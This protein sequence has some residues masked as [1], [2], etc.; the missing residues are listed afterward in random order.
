M[1]KVARN[2]VEF[3][4][5]VRV[6]SGKKTLT[7]FPIYRGQRD[8]SWPLLPKI[9]RPP[10][11]GRPNMFCEVI[12]P[13]LYRGQDSD[14]MLVFKDFDRLTAS[15]MP[16]WVL[17]GEDET[18]SWRKLLLAQ[19]HGLATRLLDW[20]MNP[21]VA[22]Y[23]AVEDEETECNEKSPCSYCGSDRFHDSAVYVLKERLSFSIEGL[24]EEYRSN[25]PAPYYGWGG[26]TGNDVGVLCP[27]NISPRVAAQ[28]S[29]FTIR[30]IPSQE[31]STD[32]AIRIPHGSREAI[33][34]EL[35]GLGINQGTLFPDL[36]G[37]AQY[38]KW[39]HPGKLD[40]S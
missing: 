25:G 33:L 11:A 31:I 36:D 28:G 12:A 16:A 4:E 34:E 5:A 29:V 14:E 21:L 9:A 39:R 15:M 24:V 10:F 38:L 35:D 19:H 8:V 13:L 40:G 22:L 27:P 23:F 20:T 6:S 3:L 32:G 26:E 2:M 17:Q 1:E 30:K 37:V 7:C 18:V